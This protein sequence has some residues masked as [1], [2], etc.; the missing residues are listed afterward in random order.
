MVLNSLLKVIDMGKYRVC[1]ALSPPRSSSMYA[2][3]ALSLF[4]VIAF[5]YS[6]DLT[7]H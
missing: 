2:I 3:V 1:S 6:S 7:L 5:I 4:I